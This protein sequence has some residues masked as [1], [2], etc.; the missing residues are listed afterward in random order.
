MQREGLPSALFRRKEVP[1][2]PF[3]FGRRLGPGHTPG[4]AGTVRAG[5]AGGQSRLGGVVLVLG[6]DGWLVFFGVGA[7]L[8]WWF[9]RENHPFSWGSN[10][11]KDTVTWVCL[12]RR[13][14][15]QTGVVRFRLRRTLNGIGQIRESLRLWEFGQF[16]MEHRQQ[17]HRPN[18]MWVMSKKS[19][20][21][22]MDEIRSHHFE[23]MG[24][25]C[26]SILTGASS[27]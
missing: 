12:S 14:A 4:A 5:A 10:L 16:H 26:L 8:I 22:W 6:K 24:D 15:N 3:F 23:T 18:L 1:P 7:A 13:E 2:G 27:F 25:N 21:L 9:S 11:E 17:E 20:V 19:S